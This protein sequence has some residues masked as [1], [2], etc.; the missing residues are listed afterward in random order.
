MLLRHELNHAWTRF[1]SLLFKFEGLVVRQ[2]PFEYQ[3]RTDLEEKKKQTAYLT[4]TWCVCEAVCVDWQVGS[5][6]TE[7]P[8][9]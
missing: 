2:I 6:G 9:A 3:S 5:A 1:I 4:D 7:K 8:R